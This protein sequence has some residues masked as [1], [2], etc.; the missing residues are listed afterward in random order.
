MCFLRLCGH[1]LYL[2]FMTE[3]AEKYKYGIVLNDIGLR[4]LMSDAIQ[5]G[6]ISVKE[7]KEEIKNTIFSTKLDG[8]F[9]GCVE[10]AVGSFNLAKFI[11]EMFRVHNKHIGVVVKVKLRGLHRQLSSTES[12]RS[13][14][15]AILTSH[16]DVFPPNE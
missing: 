16:R 6:N 13:I 10:G 1:D 11:L 3:P 14:Q 7:G 8:P 5:I 4:R 15:D 2:K 9:I 12:L